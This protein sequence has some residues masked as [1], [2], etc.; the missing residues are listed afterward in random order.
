MAVSTGGRRKSGAE[1]TPA[2]GGSAERFRRAGDLDKAIALCREGLKK[3]PDQT[4]ARVT[5]G[6]ALLDQGKYDEA[7]AELELALKRAPDNLAAIRGLAELHDRA[8]MLPMDGPGQWPPDAGMIDEAMEAV[9][10]SAE[11]A[12]PAPEAVT[13]PLPTTSTPP[14]V[15]T[16]AK[17]V[18]RDDAGYSPEDIRDVAK[19]PEKPKRAHRATVDIDPPMTAAEVEALVAT[20]RAAASTTVEPAAS[21]PA[22]ASASSASEITDKIPIPDLPQSLVADLVSPAAAAMAAAHHVE[23]V[24]DVVAVAAPL[25][26]E[27]D[28]FVAAGIDL[29][30]E[31]P[32]AAAVEDSIV[33]ATM[34]F[35]DVTLGSPAAAPEPVAMTGDA[36]ALIDDR[37]VVGHEAFDAA[38][39]ESIAALEDL[40]AAEPESVD[41]VAAEPVTIGAGEGE[42]QA[43]EPV[44]LST[45][46]ELAALELEA[47]EFHAPAPPDAAIGDV[48]LTRD[49]DPVD[50]P[51]AA[52]HPMTDEPAIDLAIAAGG[53][54]PE[55][56]L[57]LMAS[58][59]AAIPSADFVAPEL[60]R[61]LA[62]SSPQ[63]A[64]DDAHD[65]SA[66]GDMDVV[67]DAYHALAEA[68]VAIDSFP[69]RELNL[70]AHVDEPAASFDDHF[71]QAPHA[72]AMAFPVGEMPTP[73]VDAATESPEI[74]FAAHITAPGDDTSQHV[75]E[76]F[77]PPVLAA[78]TAPIVDD[79]VVIAQAPWGGT[80]VVDFAAPQSPAVVAQSIDDGP[81]MMHTPVPALPVLEPAAAAAALVT[82]APVVPLGAARP[83]AIRLHRM[84]QRIEARR[85]ELANKSVA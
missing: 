57:E 76:Q 23:P 56:E 80:G 47:A 39:V 40:S 74:D 81:V 20:P 28:E 27:T 41:L 68:P 22:P 48:A 43:V 12:A 49:L 37:E 30:P 55:V 32:P 6:W 54:E 79:E 25:P 70:G 50:L 46:I 34:A 21:V 42:T 11:T 18:D 85:L 59:D 4:S 64:D 66:L 19:R 7:R 82:S 84:L 78:P 33:P 9:E 65:A 61:D 63:R 71:A 35:S 26:A 13:S 69:D 3:F 60:A 51:L 1:N 83:R 77:A 62:V 10:E 15:V 45:P 53:A 75:N 17:T 38:S 14:D 72:E 58:A 24:E 2:F 8:D 73:D 44:E 29:D 36:L 67:A 16:T 5:L 52:D 31:L